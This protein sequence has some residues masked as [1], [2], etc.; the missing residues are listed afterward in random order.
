MAH[1]CPRYGD[2]VPIGFSCTAHM[3]GMI[4]YALL[5]LNRQHVKN[6]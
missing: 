2:P 1:K 5:D 3:N 6:I 4:F